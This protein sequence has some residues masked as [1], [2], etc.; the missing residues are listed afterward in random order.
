MDGCQLFQ[1]ES[2][3]VMS[4]TRRTVSVEIVYMGNACADVCPF[5]YDGSQCRRFGKIADCGMEDGETYIDYPSVFAGRCDEC[6]AEDAHALTVV[7][8][9]GSPK[10]IVTITPD[11]ARKIR[12]ELKENE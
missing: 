7:P 8:S 9:D 11:M 1:R 6:K 4:E 3:P 5:L 12:R 10:Y 2:D